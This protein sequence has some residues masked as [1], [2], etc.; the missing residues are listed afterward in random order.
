MQPFAAA[1]GRAALAELNR[2]ATAGEPFSLV[3]L[4][5]M[6]PEMDGF[7]LARHIRAASTL[8]GT[9]LIMLASGA[10]PEE[11]A[12]ARELGIAVYLLKPVK[13]SELLDAIVTGLHLAAPRPEP[14]P[15]AP[16]AALGQGLRILLAEDNPVNQKLAV[17]LLRK[18][19]HTVQVAGNGREAL[20]AL[21]LDGGPAPAEPFDVVLMDVQMPEMDGF[22]ATALIRER[23][24]DTGRHLPVIAMTAYAMK[25]DRE[26]CLAA[27]MDGY[28]AK[29]VQPA[30]LVRALSG[31]RTG[32]AVSGAVL[33]AGPADELIDRAAALERVGGDKQLLAEL[34]KLFRREWPGWLTEIRAAVAAGDAAR[35]R[36]FAHT[37]RGSAA[38]FGA[39]AACAAAQRLETLAQTGNLTGADEAT[40]VLAAALERLQPALAALADG[41][42]TR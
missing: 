12:R 40:T 37:L 14:A 18:Q 33:A 16:P 15:T 29:P 28:V 10:R 2:A 5:A 30:E 42:S 31:L 17:A 34:A 24:R 9:T 41:N 6:M 39:R 22:Q 36:L 23:E 8:A 26:R 13:Q 4:D 19:G 21:G 25:G 27:G 11:A 1:D 3:L 35:L 20:R 38:N 7:T 32:T